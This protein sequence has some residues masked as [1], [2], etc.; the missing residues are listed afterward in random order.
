MTRNLLPILGLLAVLSPFTV[1]AIELD[2]APVYEDR[3]FVPEQY[4]WDMTLFYA[5]WDEWEADLKKV[6]ELYDKMVGFKGQ[7]GDSPEKLIEF[8]ALSDESG[9]LLEKTWGYAAKIEDLDTRDNFVKGKYN[10]LVQT[11]MSLYAKLSWVEPELL[12]IPEET[13]TDWID[14]NSAL[15]PHRFGLLDSYRTAKYTLD[16]T[17]EKILSLH[18]SVRGTPR[19]IYNSIT[20]SDGESPEVI[21][22]NGKKVNVSAGYYSNALNTLRDPKDRKNIQLARMEQFEDRENTFAS[23]YNGVIQQGWALAQS[24]GYDSTLEMK[25]NRND[26]PTEVVF[27]LIESARSGAEELQ[28]Y[29]RLRQS[30]L[31][32]KDYGWSD[33]FVPLLPSE[34]HYSY[35]K[36]IPWIVDSVAPLGEEYQTKTAEQFKAG[37]VDV[38][39]TPGK[40]SGAYNSG[41]YS[42]GSFILLNY[43]GGL[44]DVFTTAHEMGHS[45][46]TRLAIE[47][48]PYPTSDYTIFVAEVAST[49]N[50]K[51][52]L[53]KL[54][55]EINDPKDRI[56]FIEQQID[57]I[58]GTYFLQT[59]MADFEIQAHKLVESGQGLTAERLTALWKE[60]VSSYFGDI[61]PEDDP[62]MTSWA[63]I[64]H[65]YNSPFYVYQY[66]T[67]YASSSYLMKQMEKD[68]AVVGKYLELLKSG[69]N[70]HP[71]NQLKKA[72]VDLTD[73]EIL[74]AV[75]EEF[76]R[77]VDLLEQEYTK[78][79]DETRV[80]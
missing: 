64:P 4:K 47:Y 40:R 20:N 62:Y 26:I 72:G 39:E 15:E 51:L 78:Y 60:V 34:K 67:C 68:P 43:Q 57:Q 74:Q 38:Y 35:D 29:H 12:Q 14:E 80:G 58:R 44:E 69:G 22:S 50:E 33:M 41:N 25:L 53:N 24:R 36:I 49:L 66:A 10:K 46:H 5:S 79:L 6:T 3:S 30:F 54:L 13:M 16:E 76:S 71:M 37:L 59:M 70:D 21:L 18:G 77:L 28:R 32:L 1:Q 61:I 7:L 11:Y 73:P 23:I 8:L 42:V 2:V 19:D 27:K 55:S 48:Q 52:L 17:G 63:R 56:A 75:V 65:L 45:M 9:I 31:G